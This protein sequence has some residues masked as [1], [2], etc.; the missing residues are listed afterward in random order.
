MTLLG[1]AQARAVGHLLKLEITDWDDVPMAC[2]PLFRCLQTA[3]II[4]DE[5]GFDVERVTY[6]DRLMERHWGRW[7][8]LLDS[9]IRVRYP[10]DWA[11]RAADKWGWPFPG[12]GENYPMLEERISG[13]LAEQTPD[14]TMVVVSHGEAGRIIRRLYLGTS[15]EETVSLPV[16][17]NAV[18]RLEGDTCEE[19]PTD[20]SRY[21]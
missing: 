7:Q 5:I 4:C 2:S 21:L 13:W 18:F 17:Q 6:D 12:G 3:A 14:Q 11:A 20:P 16:P 15:P 8:T 10:D 9:E 1:T 19:L